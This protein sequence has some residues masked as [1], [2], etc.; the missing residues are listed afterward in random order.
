M[1]YNRSISL[2]LALG[3]LLGCLLTPK[4]AYACGGAPVDRTGPW[5]SASTALLL[6]KATSVSGDGRQAVLQVAAYAGPPAPA[7]VV[8]SL[9][10][11]ENRV[12]RGAKC[13]D[14]SIRF[15]KGLDYVVFL[16]SLPPALQLA[17]PSGVTAYP[18]PEDGVVPELGLTRDDLIKQFAAEHHYQ[19]TLPSDRTHVEWQA[20][21]GPSQWLWLPA[22]A[23]LLFLLIGSIW[24]IIIV[25]RRKLSPVQDR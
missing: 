7:P 9:P 24:R 18:V 20:P 21:R 4:S 22:A 14:P 17:D 10:S 1:S 2:L 12:P 3:L 25:L 11:T 5:P 6:G 16:S 19:V 13:I 15:T 23:L 8:V